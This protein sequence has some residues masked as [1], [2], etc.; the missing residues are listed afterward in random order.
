MSHDLDPSIAMNVQLG[1]AVAAKHIAEARLTAQFDA[2]YEFGGL[3]P[4]L[5]IITILTERL[6]E[7]IRAEA[8]RGGVR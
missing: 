7:R 4:C 8:E 2:L 6:A 5:H 3:A 1:Q